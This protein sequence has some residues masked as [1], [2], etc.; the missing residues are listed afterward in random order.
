MFND[1]DTSN[2]TTTDY[3]FAGPTTP[4]ETTETT[5]ASHDTADRGEGKEASASAKLRF[6]DDLAVG[7]GG[8]GEG[9]GEGEEVI[10]DYGSFE[11]A[12]ES[13][14]AFTDPTISWYKPRLAR[15]EDILG[16]VTLF[17]LFLISYIIF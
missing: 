7:S 10:G 9:E 14:M 6:E 11:V 15:I 12:G 8:E 16:N 1:D 13:E 2:D 5:N 3:E 17:L 4:V